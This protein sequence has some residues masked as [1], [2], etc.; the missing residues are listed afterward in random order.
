[1]SWT[2]IKCFNWDIILTIDFWLDFHFFLKK[3]VWIFLGSSQSFKLVLTLAGTASRFQ[4]I[5]KLLKPEY[6]STR[7]KL[8]VWSSMW[9]HVLI[10][11]LAFSL[12][13]A[14]VLPPWCS[15]SSS[16]PLS[17]Q[18]GSGRA[19]CGAEQ[20]LKGPGEVCGGPWHRS[21]VSFTFPNFLCHSSFLFLLH[22]N[23]LF[24]VFDRAD[25]KGWI[26]LQVWKVC[27][28]PHL[29]RLS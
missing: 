20:C 19:S 29:L 12:A 17:C 16:D 27:R 25:R 13:A 9:S 11:L 7:K 10:S 14:L 26:H 1:M 3:Q 6:G 21:T 28:R 18:F 23:M 8:P 24:Q 5:G 15:S 22:N 2:L 4:I